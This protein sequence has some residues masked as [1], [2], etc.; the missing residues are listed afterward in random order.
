MKPAYEDPTPPPWDC[1]CGKE[2]EKRRVVLTY[3][4]NEFTVELYQCPSCRFVY[5]P[6]DLALGKMAEVEKILEDK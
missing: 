6:E 4:G 5:V 1:A 3:M 2:L